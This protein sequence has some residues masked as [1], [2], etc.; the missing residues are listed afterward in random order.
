VAG[1]FLD[2]LLGRTPEASPEVKEALAELDRLEA[3]RPTLAGPVLLL[4]DVLPLL[5]AAP[6]GDL[7]L[8]LSS[9]EMAAKLASGLPLLR[10]ESGFLD[11][12]AVGRLWQDVCAAVARHPSGE[13][14]QALAKAANAGRLDLAALTSDVLAGRPESAAARADVLGLDA[15][16]TGT[17]LRLTLLPFLV[18]A[19]SSLAGDGPTWERGYCP[20]C[21]G[22][23]LL[24]E[25]RG[26]DQ[27]RVLRCGL[28]AGGWE[29]SRQFCPFCGTRDYKLLGYFAPESEESRYRVATCDNCGGYVKTLNTLTPLTAPGLLVADV[30]TLPL[31][32]AAAER[33]FTPPG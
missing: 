13:A 26:L 30:A 5:F 12:K 33:G 21:G 10:G 6:L 4:R 31:D 20:G 23:P 27:T 2:R 1:G 9:D 15:G 32:L 7:H 22:W 28:C 19:R 29:C 17:L 11:F 3:A 25:F 18:R 8:S 24:A 16:L 14:A